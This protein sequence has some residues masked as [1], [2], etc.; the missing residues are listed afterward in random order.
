MNSS[1][2]SDKHLQL[3]YVIPAPRSDKLGN[4]DFGPQDFQS[5]NDDVDGYSLMTYDFSDPYHP[6]P[7]APLGWIRSSMEVMLGA[8]DDT[9][10]KYGQKIFLGINF[11]GNDFELSKGMLMHFAPKSVHQLSLF[12]LGVNCFN[13]WK[14][15]VQ[16]N[17]KTRDSQFAD[18][19]CNIV[20]MISS[21]IL[22]RNGKT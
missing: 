9:A 21:I 12:I 5:L 20:L 16:G 3:I 11:Y 15:W 10:G 18:F 1:E 6:G 19:V 4:Y 2:D 17:D 13:F 8:S 22:I 7:N 14:F